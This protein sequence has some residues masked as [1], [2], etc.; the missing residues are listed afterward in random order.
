MYRSKRDVDRYVNEIERTAK[1]DIE[2]DLKC[3]TVAKLYYN[4]G[5][6]QA[7]LVYLDKYDTSRKNS[8]SSLKLRAQVS[9]TA[10]QFFGLL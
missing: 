5:E 8:A 7:A 10:C 4:V 3:L 1:S 2:K 9:R 6:Y